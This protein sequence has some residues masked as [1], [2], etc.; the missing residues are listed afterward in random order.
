MRADSG[1]VQ[2]VGVSS[3]HA[4]LPIQLATFFFS[5]AISY[6]A[7][8]LGQAFTIVYEEKGGYSFR[9]VLLFCAQA[10]RISK[11]VTKEEEEE[12]E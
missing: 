1:D 12:E 5:T 9:Y 2:Q 8:V 4:A 3:A 7:R 11:E 10:D 6:R